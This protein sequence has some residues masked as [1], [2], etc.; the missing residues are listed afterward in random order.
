[1][2]FLYI[3]LA[4]FLLVFLICLINIRITLL[5]DNKGAILKIG[6]LFIDYNVTGEKKKN[7]KKQKT[8]ENISDGSPT[9]SGT[10]SKKENSKISKLIS[11]FTED[12]ELGDFIDFLLNFLGKLVNVFQSHLKVRLKRFNISV[13][14]KTPADTAIRFGIISQSCAYLFE[15]LDNNTKL[16]PLKNSN[17]YVNADYNSD[18]IFCNIKL[19]IRIRVIHVLKYLFELFIELINTKERLNKKKGQR[20]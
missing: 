13:G 17:V 15:F 10:P 7:T 20:K 16:Y 3:L 19:V 11:E 18:S 1:M 14:A 6:A 5:Y 12:F 2:V 4:L 9:E 8:K